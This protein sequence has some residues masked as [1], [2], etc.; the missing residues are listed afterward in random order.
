FVTP[1]KPERERTEKTA[2]GPAAAEPPAS[3]RD[4]AAA[5]EKSEVR[6]TAPTKR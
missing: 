1:E 6:A 2:T 5:P 3:G 4:E